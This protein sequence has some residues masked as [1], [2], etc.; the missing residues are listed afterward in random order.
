VAVLLTGAS[1][2]VGMEIL[3]RWLERSDRRI[4]A[5]VRADDNQAAAKRLEPGLDSAF[6]DGNCF[7]GQ[8]VALAG[9][10]EQPGLGLPE[11][12]LEELA[13]D[14]E[15]VIHAAASVSFT[16]DLE[17]SRRINVGGTRNMLDFAERCRRL[18]RFSHVST[19]YVAG[20]YPGVFREDQLQEGQE[21]RNPYE[22]SKF[23]AERLV[24]GRSHLLPVQVLRP[25]IVVGE[26][27]SG[28]TPSFNVLYSPLKAFARGAFPALPGRADAPVDVVPVD[29]VADAAY[30][31]SANGPEGTFH[32]VAGRKATSVGRL[33]ELASRHFGKK[34]PPAF[35]PPIYRRLVYPLALRRLGGRA[36]ERLRKAEVFFPYFSMQVRYDDRR[37][38]ERLEPLGIRVTPVEG[39]FHRLL[40]FANRADWG[41]RRV[42]RW[43]ARA[44]RAEGLR[45]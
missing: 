28:W 16:L 30:E 43:T 29:Y 18:R 36:R 20:T 19:A 13:R 25:S 15:I 31:L 5:I 35:P 38:R 45:T 42:E 21:F 41:K 23:E 14:V 27:P 22:Q 11:S 7:D 24:Q 8:V 33:A 2:F 3:T 4:Y 34:P 40:E 17:E 6:G 10:V 26:R 1:G 12:R 44:W 32:L 37:A 39:Y 9:D